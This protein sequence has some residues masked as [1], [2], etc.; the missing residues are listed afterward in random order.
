MTTLQQS[1]NLPLTRA[2]AIAEGHLVDLGLW[3]TWCHFKKP[4]AC[5]AAVWNRY[6]VPNVG[7]RALYREYEQG[8]AVAIL[9]ALYAAIGD[10]IPKAR[11]YLFEVSIRLDDEQVHKIRLKVLY[12]PGDTGEP[13]RTILL[14]DDNYPQ[15]EG[16]CS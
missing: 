10:G 1:E 11:Q 2:R 5:S 12:G 14:P 7:L 13:V 15:S 9:L 16:E 4:V 3:A 6:I 8:R